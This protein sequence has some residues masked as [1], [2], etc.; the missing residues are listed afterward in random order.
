MG[1]EREGEWEGVVWGSRQNAR[2][3]GCGGVGRMQGVR[4]EW[5]GE[6]GRVWCGGVGRMQGV[7]DE[8]EG[9]WGR[10]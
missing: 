5:E 8:R 9:E 10:V 6:W 4:D 1:G 2:G 3:E 7:R